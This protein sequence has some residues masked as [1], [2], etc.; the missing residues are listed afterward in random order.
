M[1]RTF[2][3]RQCLWARQGWGGHRDLFQARHGEQHVRVFRGER[4]CHVLRNRIYHGTNA[5]R[6]GG[7]KSKDFLFWGFIFLAED[8][9]G[10]VVR[11]QMVKGLAEGFGF[12]L[13][14]DKELLKE[15]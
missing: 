6:A 4:V 11:S 15:Y 8:E 13:I 10:E 9:K 12:Q 1:S 7:W 3:G 14:G 5:P 2:A